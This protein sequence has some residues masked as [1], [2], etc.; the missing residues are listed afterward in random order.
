MEC[1]ETWKVAMNY[2]QQ[3][4]LHVCRDRIVFCAIHNT[5][6]IESKVGRRLFSLEL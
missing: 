4:K 5:N 1:P 3:D 6:S 2:S